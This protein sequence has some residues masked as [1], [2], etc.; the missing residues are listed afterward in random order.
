M[1]KERKIGFRFEL[2]CGKASFA[3]AGRKTAHGIIK[4]IDEK[5]VAGCSNG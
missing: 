5:I 2:E 1:A 4:E 3:R